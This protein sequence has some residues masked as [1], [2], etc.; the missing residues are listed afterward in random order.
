MLVVITLIL[1]IGACLSYF[2]G[3][4]DLID[5]EIRGLSATQLLSY[6]KTEL[7]SSIKNWLEGRPNPACTTA[8][9]DLITTFGNFALPESVSVRQYLQPAVSAPT[10]LQSFH[11]THPEVSLPCF[12]TPARYKNFSMR[13]FKA[14][15]FRVGQPNYLSLTTE[16]GVKL[17]FEMHYQ[18]G[19]AP[20]K[21]FRQKFNLRYRLEA[22][23]LGNYGLIFTNSPRGALAVEAS[24]PG[25]TK[26]IV[27]SK[28]LVLGPAPE[29]TS[30]AWFGSD[31][32]HLT[33]FQNEVHVSATH[34]VVDNNALP[35]VRANGMDK[36][37]RR[38]VFTEVV[39]S[40]ETSS[41]YEYPTTAGGQAWQESF[42]YYYWDRA[43]HLPF[44]PTLRSAVPAV[45]AGGDTF[46]S[47]QLGATTLGPADP[48]LTDTSRIFSTALMGGNPAFVHRTCRFSAAT[49][50]GA[51][52]RLMMWSNRDTTFTVDLSANTS[53]GLPPIF[54]G[55]IAARRLIIKLNNLETSNPADPFTHHY[56]IGKFMVS[57][58]ITI[59]GKGKVHFIDG[60]GFQK[61]DVALPGLQSQDLDPSLI[62]Q[63]L[64]AYSYSTYRNFFMPFLRPGETYAALPSDLGWVR[65]MSTIDWGFTNP[66]PPT[67]TGYRCASTMNIPTMLI[68]STGRRS[69]PLIDQ[70]LPKLFFTARSTL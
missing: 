28:T 8:R 36:V 34:V 61:E 2:L 33:E 70:T 41:G 37:F 32:T 54:C 23:S 52:A 44:G 19:G 45:S 43:G 69:Y 63:H 64:Y 47:N 40:P 60:I 14:D 68:D 50:G 51:P 58:G 39:P 15:F 46:F 18:V 9:T 53:A 56:L 26:V 7:E 13:N 65:P 12:L 42:N 49:G 35:Y 20:A 1:S 48:R 57:E 4:T 5:S 25:S 31:E 3:T 55:V 11:A 21:T 24:D 62:T 38:G 10:S 66:C 27:A 6:Q 16:V 22:S 59:M 67:A 29:L 17:S 30:L